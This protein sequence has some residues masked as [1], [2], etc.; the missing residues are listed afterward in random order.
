[1]SDMCQLPD[2]ADSYTR[3]NIELYSLGHHR[4]SPQNDGYD[5][6]ESPQGSPALQF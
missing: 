2:T 6:R 4:P 1:M 3:K 5:G